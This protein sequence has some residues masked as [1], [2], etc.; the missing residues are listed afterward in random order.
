MVKT[1]LILFFVPA[2]CWAR[3]ELLCLT[4]QINSARTRTDTE[5]LHKSSIMLTGAHTENTLSFSL[6]DSA[7]AFSMTS[8][9]YKAMITSCYPSSLSLTPVPEARI[10]HGKLPSHNYSSFSAMPLCFGPVQHLDFRTTLSWMAR[11]HFKWQFK[12]LGFLA[13]HQSIFPHFFFFSRIDMRFCE[14]A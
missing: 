12:G 5:V 10:N 6:C 14:C 8:A 2:T 4:W 7:I 9:L 1:V 11:E 13:A 3:L